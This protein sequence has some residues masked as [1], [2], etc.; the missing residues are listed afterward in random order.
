[1]ENHDLKTRCLLRNFH[2]LFNGLIITFLFMLVIVSLTSCEDQKLAKAID[3]SWKI[4]NI[5]MEEDGIPY[6]GSIMYSFV[7]NPK[8]KDRDG[9]LFV[10]F[11]DVEFKHNEE[12]ITL[13]GNIDVSLQGDW[14]ILNGDLI[15]TYDESKVNVSINNFYSNI[16]EI[17]EYYNSRQLLDMYMAGEYLPGYNEPVD[18]FPSMDEMSEDLKKE[19]YQET[20]NELRKSGYEQTYNNIEIKDDVLTFEIEGGEKRRLTRP[21]GNPSDIN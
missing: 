13:S 20:L 3:G 21:S 18:Y 12:G 7:Y 19:A 17:A 5:T 14:E 11:R 8:L 4:G 10:E 1:M 9:G 16:P 6:T 15:L 2:T